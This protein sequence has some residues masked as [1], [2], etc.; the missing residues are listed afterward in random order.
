MRIADDAGRQVV[1]DVLRIL[2]EARIGI[3]LLRTFTVKE[4]GR[5]VGMAAC[6]GGR[7]LGGKGVD[8]HARYRGGR[9]SVKV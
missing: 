5:D 1:G 4:K 7:R 6:L 2:T 9:S 3:V 8:R